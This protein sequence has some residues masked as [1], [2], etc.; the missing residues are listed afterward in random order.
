MN[1]YENN[2]HRLFLVSVYLLKQLQRNLAL[3]LYIVREKINP[4]EFPR[5]LMTL[6]KIKE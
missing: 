1:S 2:I 4:W 5:I 6:S 3:Y